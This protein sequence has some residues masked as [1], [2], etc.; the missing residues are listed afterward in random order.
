LLRLLF[1]GELQLDV[2]NAAGYLDHHPNSADLY[3]AV[4]ELHE[5]AGSHRRARAHAREAVLLD[6]L[7]EQ[8]RCRARTLL[9]ASD[10]GQGDCP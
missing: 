6:P 10:V 8:T 3:L 5:K 2:D 1:T 4:A 7:G 9:A